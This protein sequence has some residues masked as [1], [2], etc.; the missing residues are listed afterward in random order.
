MSRNQKLKILRILD[1]YGMGGVSSFL[2]S[3]QSSSQTQE[4][5]FQA[6]NSHQASDAVLTWHPD[7]AVWHRACSWAFL[8][9]LLW[10]KQYTKLVIHEHNYCA[11]YEATVPS[12]KRF[13][14]GL[15]LAYGLADR[16]VAISHAQADWMLTN[17]LVDSRKLK[18]IQQCRNL[19]D[20]LAVPAPQTVNTPILLGAYGRFVPQKGFDTLLQ[21]L[22]QLTDLPI[23]LHLAG[24]GPEAATLKNLAQGIDTIKFVGATQNVPD[25][26]SQCDAVVIPSRWEPWGMVCIEA[27]A[28]ARPIICS[29]VDGL[30]EQIIDCGI[31]VPPDDPQALATALRTMVS[32]PHDQL[33][34]WGHNGRQSVL[35]AWP[36]HL[37]SW[38]ALFQEVL[39]SA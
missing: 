18:V 21:A 24:D 7:I 38:K 9:K 23:H 31:L 35:S 27:K 6:V 5:S 17:Q 11:A 28:A 36:K 22:Q 37:N 25:F 10:I 29:R 34:M 39:Q 19:E 3:W 33:L 26:L 12:L 14:T 13:H 4:F 2:A 16:V 32:L 1:E 8:P 15:R 30:T 20:F